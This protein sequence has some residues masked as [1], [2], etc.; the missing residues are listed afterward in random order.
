M[1]PRS[2]TIFALTVAALGLTGCSGSDGMGQVNLQLATRSTAMAA[3]GAARPQLSSVAGQTVV[4]LGGD[5]IVFERVEL[6]LRKV[7]FEGPEVCAGTP[8][9]TEAE[10]ESEDCGEF[11]AG[12]TLFDL[13]LG[14]GAVQTFTATVPAGSYREVKFQ[15]HRPVDANGDAAF[16]AAHPDLAGVSIRVTGTY[17][18]AG[19]PAPT[20]FSYTTDLTSEVEVELP[21]PVTVAAGADLAVTLS[22]DLTGWFANG[23]GTGLVDPAQALGGQP[24]ESL[25]EQHIRSSFH[26]F[27]DENK[28]GEAD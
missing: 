14:D 17:Q 10:V 25:V 21:A 5:Q 13:P 26:A 4:S 28:D 23:D 6:V 24:L 12:P 9:S 3:T 2:S 8:G 11:S 16:L 15:I 7:K 19:D 1:M 20:P 18:H 22:I 27:E